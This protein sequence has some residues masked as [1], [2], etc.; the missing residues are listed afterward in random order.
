MSDAARTEKPY[1]KL[2]GRKSTGFHTRDRLWLGRDHL[3]LVI[4]ASVGYEEIYRRFFFSEIQGF[5]I[6]KTRDAAFWNVVFVLIALGTAA[7]GAIFFEQTHMAHPTAR[8]FEVVGT[9]CLVYTF[10]FAVALIINILRGPTC[11]CFIRTAVKE[12]EL[13]P[14]ARIKIARKV[15]GMIEE[16]IAEAQPPLDDAAVAAR[17]AATP[18]PAPALPAPPPLLTAR[19]DAGAQRPFIALTLLLFIDAAT[20]FIGLTHNSTP[21]LLF[22]WLM[23]ILL[24]VSTVFAMARGARTVVPR[25]VKFMTGTIF[26]YLAVCF[27]ASWF[28][29]IAVQVRYPELMRG[30][31][32]NF[33]RY[34]AR[35]DPGTTPFLAGTHIATLLASAALCLTSAVILL[36]TDR[37]AIAASGR[38]SR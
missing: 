16:K 4:R 9:F 8:F 12:E 26:A 5:R 18:S 23:A 32:M 2:P 28:Y 7:A 35:L 22:T 29:F 24:L 10:L 1:R 36:R 31:P 20:S 37:D 33:L 17:I 14:I 15:I 3:L 11:R 30:H 13:H 6:E 38:S 25:S 34:Q 27:L 19:W 21:Y